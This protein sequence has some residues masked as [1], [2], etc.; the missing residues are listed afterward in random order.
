[1]P[2][3]TRTC[4]TLLPDTHMASP[5]M[6]AELKRRV[7]TRQAIYRMP[8]VPRLK[9]IPKRAGTAGK[10]YDCWGHRAC[11]ARL[12]TKAACSPPP[13]GEH[14]GKGRRRSPLP[15]SGDAEFSHDAM[16]SNFS[17]AIHGG[18][19]EAAGMMRSRLRAEGVVAAGI[20]EAMAVLG[21]VLFPPLPPA[22]VSPC[23]FSD[24]AL[25]AT[26]LAC[27]TPRAVRPHP[28]G[29]MLRRRCGTQ[30]ARC[31]NTR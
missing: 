29:R 11:F 16:F 26:N 7:Y 1:M 21:H 27:L 25:Q 24:S 18:G 12:A 28:F 8:C 13:R 31:P 10:L 4:T 6:A 15:K 19:K 5:H 2:P 22:A 20:L 23:G 14:P 30:N 9:Q 17:D 3:A